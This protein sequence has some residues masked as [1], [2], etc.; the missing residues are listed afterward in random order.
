MKKQHIFCILFLLLAL[1]SYAQ[2]NIRS[3]AIKVGIMLPLHDIDGD[4]RRMVEYYRGF[5]LACNDLKEK[6]I[7]ADI[8]AWNVP[9]D[10]DIR[11]TLL[12]PAAS[13]CDIIVGPLYTAQVK[14]LG[15]FCRN[16]HIRMVIPFSIA[17][18]EVNHNPQISQVYQSVSALN[19]QAIA[20]FLERFPK[21]HPVFIDCND[22]TSR[23][24]IFTFG[25]R[26][27]LEKKGISYSITNLRSSEE[28]FAKAFSRK[29]PNVVVLNTGRSPELNIALAK[30]NGLVTV[31]PDLSISLFGYTEWL[32]YK[33]YNMENFHRFDTYIPTTF[34]YNPLAPDVQ[35]IE[36]LYRQ[37]FHQ[38][39]QVAL[40]RFAI[41]GYDH[42]RFFLEGLH[43]YG[44]DFTGGRGQQVSSP[45]QSPLQFVKTPQGG[46]QNRH[47]QLIHYKQDQLTESITY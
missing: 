46:M 38:D 15:D 43:T 9:I 7:S 35:R 40:P 20:A 42:A 5:L 45:L 11:Q 13:Q 21:H 36:K 37:W 25:L 2:S 34:Y 32:M 39:M 1:A 44:N 28:Q 14:Y 4:G 19:D 33:K 23:K 12:D 6:G 17:S 8:H 24:G 3:R 18:E 16:Y 29:K 41:T 22:T 10:A 27:R 30:L 47:F 26:Q 31:S